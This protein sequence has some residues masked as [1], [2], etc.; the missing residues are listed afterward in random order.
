M[1]VL[2]EVGFPHKN[3]VKVVSNC[4]LTV[5]ASPWPFA[6][7]YASEIEAHWQNASAA[8]PAYFNGIVHLIDDL[9]MV[10]SELHAS[11][12]RTEFKN[13]LYWRALGFPDAGVIDGFGC[14][15]IRSSDGQFML[16]IQRPGHVNSG[17]VYLPSGFIDERDVG[18]DGTIDIGASVT[19]EIDEE[20]GEAGNDLR[21]EEGFIVVRSG[22]QLGLAVPFHAP[23]TADAF[24]ARVGDHNARSDDPELEAVI[25]VGSL[26]DLQDL[27]M[28]PYARALLEA[29]LAAH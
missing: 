24:V 7:T 13:Y 15:V 1:S 2:R 3:D 11:L 6:T 18:A 28:L 5:G 16:A 25:P 26:D 17:F 10:G 29:L 27:K 19:R 22:V 9:R 14:A 20:I 12:I 23:M 8:N 21:R 4:V